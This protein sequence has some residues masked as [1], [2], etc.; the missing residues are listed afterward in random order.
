MRKKGFVE[1]SLWILDK[2]RADFSKL[3]NL[4]NSAYMIQSRGQ[5]TQ[6]GYPDV[7]SRTS[8]TF[9]NS[10]YADQKENLRHFSNHHQNFG[11]GDWKHKTEQRGSLRERSS[12]GKYDPYSHGL[13]FDS[14]IELLDLANSIFKLDKKLLKYMNYVKSEQKKMES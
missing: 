11:E 2:V 10:G 14:S 4:T 8:N 1:G 13:Q 9:E 3:K 12:H 5:A 7:F 6:G